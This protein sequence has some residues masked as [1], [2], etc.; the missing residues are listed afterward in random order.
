[1]KHDTGN[2]EER[3]YRRT[4]QGFPRFSYK[5]KKNRKKNAALQGEPYELCDADGKVLFRC[6]LE[7]AKRFLHDLTLGHFK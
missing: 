3:E 2:D 7:Q 5:L 4:R 1:M 6:R